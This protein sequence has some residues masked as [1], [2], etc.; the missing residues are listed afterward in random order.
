MSELPADGEAAKAYEA[1]VDTVLI[2][3]L[4]PKDRPDLLERLLEPD[5]RGTLATL[6]ADET[7]AFFMWR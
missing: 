5:G 1:G 7:H 4:L 2:T 6:G 3:H